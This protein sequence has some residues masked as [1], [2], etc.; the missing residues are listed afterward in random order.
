VVNVRLLMAL[1]AMA[2]IA[3]AA[4]R[5]ITDEKLRLGT[6]VILGFFAMRIVFAHTRQQREKLDE[7]GSKG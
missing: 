1:G 3:A 4:D 6:F 7:Q 2:L 5:T